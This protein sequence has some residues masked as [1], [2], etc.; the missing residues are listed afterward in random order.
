M[1]QPPQQPPHHPDPGPLHDSAVSADD[2]SFAVFMHLTLLGHLVLPVVAVI[3][4][5][6]MWQQK[7]A[8]SPFLDDH[9]REVVN[10]HLTILLYSLLLPLAALLIG[11]VTCGLGLLLL[12]PA[13]LAP[14]A[15]GIIGM[16]L[17]INASNRGAYYRYPATLRFLK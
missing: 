1:H 16:I 7:K 3:A 2:R 10:F 13:G 5:I 6:I 15:L 17:A 14:Y 4:P 8:T 11:V 9:G 12:V